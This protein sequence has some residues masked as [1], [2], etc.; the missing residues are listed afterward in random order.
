MDNSECAIIDLKISI[1]I[2]ALQT[3][4][5]EE[6]KRLLKKYGQTWGPWQAEL[7]KHKGAGQDLMG[8]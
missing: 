8:S 7:Q 1:M 3:E 5:R 6:L 4:N 2:V